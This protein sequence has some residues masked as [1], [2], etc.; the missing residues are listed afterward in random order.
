MM[1]S[2]VLRG[3]ELEIELRMLSPEHESGLVAT[4]KLRKNHEEDTDDICA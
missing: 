3:K 1:F 4:S 2:V